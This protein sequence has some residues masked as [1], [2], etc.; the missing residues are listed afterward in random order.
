MIMRHNLFSEDC[1]KIPCHP[2]P[3]NSLKSRLTSSADYFYKIH[4]VHVLKWCVII[5]QFIVNHVQHFFFWGFCWSIVKWIPL[6]QWYGHDPNYRGW[7]LLS[8][9]IFLIEVP[10]AFLLWIITLT[11]YIKL[12]INLK[13]IKY[14]TLDTV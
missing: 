12:K 11:T 4:V 3:E 6:W 14:L 7:H 8:R 2:F 5:I 9:V 1:D 10:N 13:N